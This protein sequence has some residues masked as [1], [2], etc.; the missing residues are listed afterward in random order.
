[1]AVVVSGAD[2]QTAHKTVEI[3]QA[4]FLDKVYMPVVIGLVP[5]ARQRRKLWRIHSS[6]S[7]TRCTCPLLLVWCRKPDSAENLWYS[8]GAVL[9]QVVHA[10][11]WCV[12]P[13]ARQCR[14][15]VVFHRCSSWTRFTCSSFGVWCRWPDRAENPWRFHRCSSWT[16]CSC[17]S[18]V[19]GAHGQTVQKTCGDA[20]VSVF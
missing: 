15:P 13:M 6:S 20:A 11:R 7:W 12:V 8:T 10:R 19:C 5:I 2:A 4:P 14:K 16:S 18:S 9:G 1:M 17:P 3:R